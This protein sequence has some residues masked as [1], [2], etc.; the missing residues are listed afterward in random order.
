MMKSTQ[1][2]KQRTG[3]RDTAEYYLQVKADNTIPGV[4]TNI[5][6]TGHSLG[7]GLASLLAVFF[8]ETAVTFDQAPFRNSANIAAAI[9]LRSNLVDKFPTADYPQIADWLAPLDR[10]IWSF[11]PFG[12]D[13]LAAREANVTNISV[14]GEVASTSNSFKIGI[15]LDPMSPITHG[16]YFHPVDLHSQALLTAFIQSDKSATKFDLAT[17]KRDTLSEVT[18]KLTDLLGMIF[19]NNL[20]AH[21]TDPNTKERNFLEHLVRHEAGMIDP[22]TGAV[23]IS[24]DAMVTRFTSDLWKLAQDGGMT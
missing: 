15:E 18:F 4:A 24:A 23:S 20:F 2:I 12:P 19:N 3:G 11:N 1:E 5:T 10:F 16:D 21:D 6:L 9:A 7:G 22:A 13:G 17:G 14:Q 8:N